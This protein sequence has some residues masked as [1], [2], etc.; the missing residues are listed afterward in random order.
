[1]K[2]SKILEEEGIPIDSLRP[3]PNKYCY[4]ETAGPIKARFVLF[5]GVLPLEQFAYKE[6]REFAA[7]VIEIVSKEV[8]HAEH[9][10]MT[11]HGPGMGLDEVESLSS[12]LTKG[13]S[14]SIKRI[15]FVDRSH[16]RVQR[17][18]NVLN[19]NLASVKNANKLKPD[20]SLYQIAIGKIHHMTSGDSTTGIETMSDTPASINSEF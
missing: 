6:I 1:M 13:K 7:R 8:S 11:I 12:M 19:E 14:N 15:S 20:G 3:L 4:V 5:V 16:E 2:I 17:F 10:A 9:I 18:R